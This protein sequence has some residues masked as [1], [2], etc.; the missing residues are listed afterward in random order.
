V[1]A[2]RIPCERLEDVKSGLIIRQAI[3]YEFHAKN[4]AKRLL[5]IHKKQ[6]KSQYHGCKYPGGTAAAGGV[7]MANKQQKSGSCAVP[8]PKRPERTAATL[9]T[10]KHRWVTLLGRGSI[11]DLIAESRCCWGA[12]PFWSVWVNRIMLAGLALSG[13]RPGLL[14]LLSGSQADI[15]HSFHE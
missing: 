14:L 13:L 9:L 12:S 15:F 3:L 1:L 4:Y 10:E 6:H 5:W 2:Y 7:F 8:L 11:L